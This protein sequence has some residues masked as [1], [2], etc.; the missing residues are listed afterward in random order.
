VGAQPTLEHHAKKQRL[1]PQFMP[2]AH[3]TYPNKV[4]LNWQG[5]RYQ[6]PSGKHIVA[7]TMKRAMDRL[8]SYREG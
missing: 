8:D 7:R 3:Q 6:G 5:R 4:F 2:G 1:L